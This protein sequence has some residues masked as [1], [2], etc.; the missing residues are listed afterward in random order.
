MEDF[1][2]DG[3]GLDEVGI[4]ADKGLGSLGLALLKLFVLVVDQYCLG[5]RSRC[6]G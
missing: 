5:S 3:G 4:I 1:G 6:S 2:R